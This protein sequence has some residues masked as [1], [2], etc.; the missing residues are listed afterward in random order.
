MYDVPGFKAGKEQLQPIELRELGDVRGKSLL[1]LQCHFGLD[2]LSWARH[3]AHVTGIDFSDQAIAQAWSLAEELHIPGRFI[4]CNLYD[5][6]GRLDEQFDIVFT[7]YGVLFWLPDLRRWAE[8]VAHF[9]KPG[10]VFYIVELHPFANI[11][12]I[13]DVTDLQPAYPYFSGP[14]P[15]RFETHGSYADPTADVHLEEYGWDHPLSEVI[16]ALLSAGLHLE[17]V[18][19]HPVST[20]QRFPFMVRSDNGEWRLPGKLDGMLPLLFSIRATK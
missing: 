3:G 20:Y 1:H 14:E 8:I 19:E 9:L 6:P 16:N 13:D 4:C 18:H 15:Q 5:A 2:T 11:F 12:E 10:G 17:W 7:S